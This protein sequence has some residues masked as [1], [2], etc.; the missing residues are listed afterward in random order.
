MRETKD[1]TFL[2]LNELLKKEIL[3]FPFFQTV[4]IGCARLVWISR[5]KSLTCFMNIHEVQKPE[6][7][8][9]FYFFRNSEY[10]QQALKPDIILPALPSVL[11][12]FTPS[13]SPI[14]WAII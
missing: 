5:L 1:Q 14:K 8:F 6:K 3:T 4:T 11:K 13:N 2:K 9:F 12:Y 10:P 7:A